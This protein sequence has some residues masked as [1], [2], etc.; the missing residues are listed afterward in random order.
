MKKFTLLAGFLLTLF[1]NMDAQVQVLGKNEFGR[2]FEVTYSTAE[3]NTVYATTITN[4][5]LQSKD[6]GV[7]WEV[8]FSVPAETGNITKLNISKNGSFLTFST[9][10]NGIGE[11]HIFDIATKTITKTFSMPNFSEGAYVSTYNFFGDDKDNL[12]VSSQFPY[13]F[14]TANRVYTTN[15]GGQNWKEI[16]YSVDDNHNIITSYVAFNP[17]DKNKVYIANGNGSEGVVGG[18]MISNDG[19]DTFT[20]KL[21]GSVLS[22]LEFNPNNPN[23][24]Y[25]GTGISFGMTPE[26]LHH[27]TD[28]GAT[29]EDKNIT[30]GSNG[31]LNNIIDIKYNPLDNNH[32]I[33]LEEDEIATSKD[34]GATWQ[35]VEYPY[36]SLDSY[37]YGI[38]ASFNPFKA[39]ELFITGNYKP[40]FSTDNGATLTQ[41]QTP[42]FSSTGRVSLFEN[43]TSKHLFY[44]VQNGFVHR[45]LADNSE[46]AYE[47]QA[48]NIF[49]NNNGPAYIPDSKKEGRIYS[50][51]GGF[52]GSTLAMSDNFGASFS[53]IFETFTNGL[54]NIIPDPQVTN[55]IYTTFNNWGQGELDKINF[56]NPNDIVVTNIALPVPGAV[57]KILH[58]NNISDEFFI[59]VGSE[60]YKTVNGGTDWTAVTIDTSF[61]FEA[62]VFDITQNPKNLNQ[63]ALGTSQGVYISNDKGLN[64]NQVSE[65]VAFKVSYSDKNNGV[66]VAATYTSMYTDFN[67]YYS[68]DNGTNWTTVDRTDL[69]QTDTNSIT[70]DFSDKNAY[71][72]IASADLGLLGYNLPLDV[73]AT[74]EVAGDKAQV[75]VYPNPIV[76]VLH[77][78]NKN[79]KSVALYSMEGKKLIET[80]NNEMTVSQLPKGV[81]VLRIVTSDNNIVSKKII[82]K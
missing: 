70:V 53:P 62:E 48:L 38:K 17:A 8:F 33:V 18:L 56:N 76:D 77:I 69:L 26:K 66:L 65:F 1:N 36:D 63:L 57:N 78:D 49:T 42:F 75:L 24:I 59:L 72:Y 6:N 51:K 30:W 68:V 2:I 54:T 20:T 31:I 10:K 47:I 67:I 32:I 7:S 9:L 15:D 79:L 50:Y 23:E 37:Y 3:Q 14:G 81:Y 29:W 43:E 16:Y 39:G 12:I 40:L 82:K 55:Q 11:I 61:P 73:L 28:A 44:S 52:S 35:N 58:P 41:I 80:T 5:I 27:S 4:H 25:A 46:N 22:T 45:N 74:G 60:V 13:G 71:I 34:G 19:G 64:W 21:E